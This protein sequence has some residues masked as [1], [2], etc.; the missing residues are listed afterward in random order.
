MMYQKMRK[1]LTPSTLIALIALVFALTG[2]AFAAGANSGGSD[3]RAPAS[4]GGKTIGGT[5][6]STAAKAKPKAKA[7][8]R[9]PA[10]P[11]GAA[12]PAGPAGAVGP[13]GATG[14]GGPQ[15]PAGTNGTNGTNGEPGK[16]GPEGKE[17]KEGK[18]GYAE[19]LPPGKSEYGTWGWFYSPNAGE[20]EIVTQPISFMIPL[21]ASLVAKH[22]FLLVTGKETFTEGCTGSYKEPTAEP[23]Y[24]CLYINPGLVDNLAE[25]SGGIAWPNGL[26]AIQNPEVD[27]GGADQVGRFGTSLRIVNAQAGFAEV[28][29]DWVVT[30]PPE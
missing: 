29:G 8:P 10:G 14:S 4:A 23:G 9:G 24:L 30:A 27:T 7:G 16:E 3:S 26:P 5:P 19:T 2:G 15:G 28:S 1:H 25:V 18:T 22:D 11:R 6:I 13:A 12:G 20:E 21:K 17:G